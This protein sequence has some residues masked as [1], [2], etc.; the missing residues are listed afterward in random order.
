MTTVA[1]VHLGVT[2]ILAGALSLVILV[3]AL[4][5]RVRRLR[6][7]TA[8]ALSAPAQPRP[9]AQPRTARTA[10][11]TAQEQAPVMASAAGAR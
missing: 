2:A 11:R 5:E 1:L 3:Q 4:G 9:V 7:S 10:A 6:R 8:A